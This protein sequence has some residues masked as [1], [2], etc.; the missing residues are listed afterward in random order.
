MRQG[1]KHATVY[2]KVPA[3][4]DASATPQQLS[5]SY[6]ISSNPEPS[7][8]ESQPRPAQGKGANHYRERPIVPVSQRRAP[9]LATPP[10][11]LPASVA[12]PHPDV[13]KEPSPHTP[14]KSRQSEPRRKKPISPRA[15][16]QSAP[17]RLKKKTF[18]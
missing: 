4:T 15:Q 11:S 12:T 7:L 5:A 13:T 16:S 1:L 17:G 10:P 3:Y 6:T 14:Q 8:A 2:W 18:S 9:R